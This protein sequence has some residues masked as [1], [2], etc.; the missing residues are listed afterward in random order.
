[1]KNLFSIFLTLTLVLGVIFTSCEEDTPAP[2]INFIAEADG[3]EV[4]IT[5]EATNAT[6]WEWTYGDGSIA[7]DAGSHTYTYMQS[8]EYT[9]TCKV[10]GDG[11]EALK[12]VD[13]TI[14]ASIEELISGGPEAA[15]GKTWVVNK[16]ATVGK[17]G[18]GM[19]DNNLDIHPDFS[20]VPNNMLEVFGLG[21]EYDN[22]YTFHH[23]GTYEIDPVNGQVIAGII[24]GVATQTITIPSTSPT[25]LPFCAAT[26]TA[27]DNGTW[28]LS[29]DDY[30]MG[31]IL[32]S[33]VDPDA[34]PYEVTFTFPTDNKMA[35]FN[36]SA[37][38]FLGLY[39][40]FIGEQGSVTIL[41]EIS[42]EKMHIII[43]IATNETTPHLA[44]LAFHIT[45]VPKN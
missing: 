39:D 10:K 6:T 17:D 34:D 11:G 37:G 5:A 19:V 41:K 25:M 18:A 4:T 14:V 9:I 16:L 26:Y 45:L 32:D 33:T 28:A 43:P 38:Q 30:V 27:P 29:T 40:A 15:N 42:A 7:A 36:L 13:V 23:D 21:V 3:Y 22:E 31:G 1:M 24:H 44:S 35:R 20:T 12:S 8:G 2:T